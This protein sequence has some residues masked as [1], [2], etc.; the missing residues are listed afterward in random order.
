M[1]VEVALPVPVKRLFDYKT[2]GTLIQ[3][4]CRVRVPFAGKE[5]I[6]IVC[7]LKETSDYADKKLKTILQVIDEK[8]ILPPAMMNLLWWMHRYY[9]A[10]PGEVFVNLLPKKLKNG[11]LAT[12]LNEPYWALSE[13]ASP[14]DKRAYKQQ[15]LYYFLKQTGA[16]SQTVLREDGFSSTLIRQM[17]EKGYIVKSSPVSSEQKVEYHPSQYPLTS[18]QKEAVASIRNR[19]GFS[20]NLLDGVTGS[21]K[22]EVYIQLMKHVLEQGKQVLVLVPEI[23]LTP[24][25]LHRFQARFKCPVT[26][27]HSALNDS[28][29][30]NAWL[31]ASSGSA[32]IIIG[33]RSAVLVPVPD[34]ALV[35]LDEEHDISYKQQDSL[36]Y[37]A[38]DVA[39]K[40]ASLLNCPVVL[41]SA[42]PS[43]ESWAN[44]KSGKYQH[45]RLLQRVSDKPLPKPVCIDIKDRALQA[46]LAYETVQAIEAHLQQGNQVLVFLNRR[47]YSPAIICHEC[48][49]ICECSR[50]DAHYTYHKE[51]RQLI[52]HHCGDQQK[53]PLQCEECG[54]S[55]I[56]DWGIGTEQLAEWLEQRFAKYSVVRIDRD[57][58]RKKGA[59]EKHLKEIENGEMQLLVGTQMLAKG[60]HFPNLTLSVIVNLDNALYSP[61]FRA[62]E[63]MAQLL[64]QVSGRAGR[65]N[66]PGQV[67]LQTH[68]P[69]HPYLTTL[70]EKGFAPFADLL[71]SERKQA[72]L[73][74][75]FQWAAVR[76]E[77]NKKQLTADRAQWIETLFNDFIKPHYEGLNLFVNMPALHEKKAGKYRYLMIFS[78]QSRAVLHAGLGQ[79][80]DSLLM[81]KSMQAVRWIIEID[82]VSIQG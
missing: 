52:C 5:L 26:L 67:L 31:N 38:R 82:P 15:A 3:P 58:T 29:R 72:G 22:T 17:S 45:I 36:R 61:D 49:W 73:P 28:E 81:N 66:K 76:L 47:G 10:P 27:I 33:T 48:G 55:Q 77:S 19:P 78:A 20:V 6:G 65:G 35:I 63:R 62:V 60:H 7:Q 57:S 50:C 46:G 13:N 54:S 70:I 32:R 39:V 44:A 42:T 37:N 59:L 16:T 9:L 80:Q 25:T 30:H 14:P 11:A 12:L 56:I 8:P 64:V 43:L 2:N 53:V 24:Q 74:P 18:A 75:Y 40:R 41:G 34:L 1:F 69:E 68:F 4:G 79:L 51:I 71:L 21:G 23:G